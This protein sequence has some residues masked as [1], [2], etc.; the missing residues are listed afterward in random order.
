MEKLVQL[1]H[2]GRHSLVL[3]N[4]GQVRTFD[5]RGVADL[6][7][8]LTEEPAMLREAAVA[9]K[10]VGK[11][12]AAL[13]TLG[14]VREVYAEVISRPALALL[15]EAGVPVRHG[16]AVEHIINRKGDGLC[17]VEELCLPC[18][19]AMECLPRIADFMKERNPNT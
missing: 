13:M 2:E 7:R 3:K 18:N 17:P 12:A 10:V 14:G 8:L 5:G 6:Y 1:L 16:R 4:R 11:G 9:D 19:D 15:Q